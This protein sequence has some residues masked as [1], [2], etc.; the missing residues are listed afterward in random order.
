V[1]S[2]E[3]EMQMDESDEPSEEPGC[4]IRENSGRSSRGSSDPDLTVTVVGDQCSLNGQGERGST[5]EGLQIDES[6]GQ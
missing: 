4:S 1:A 5:E 3:E 6:E 2:T